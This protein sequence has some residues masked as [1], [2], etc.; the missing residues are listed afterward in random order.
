MLPVSGAEL[1]RRRVAAEDL[2]H[3]RELE[4]PVAGAAELLVEEE[5]PQA[6]VLHVLLQVAHVGADDR[7]RQ[8]HR[9]GEDVA[10]RLDLLVAELLDPVELLL[11]LGLGGEIPGHGGVLPF[12]WLPMRAFARVGG[13]VGREPDGGTRAPGRASQLTRRIIQVHHRESQA[14]PVDK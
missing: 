14:K 4:L 8:P 10:E 9:V 11:E 6:L 12:G 13:W 7:V 1:G 3:E 2:V 5:R